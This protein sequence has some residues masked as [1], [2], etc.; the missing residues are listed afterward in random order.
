MRRALSQIPEYVAALG[1]FVGSVLGSLLDDLAL[2]AIVGAIS[3]LGTAV[4]ITRSSRTLAGAMHQPPS[5]QPVAH[6]HQADGDSNTGRHL[7][8]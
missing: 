2:G 6:G 5:N 3:G 7:P 8:D 4:L 1:L